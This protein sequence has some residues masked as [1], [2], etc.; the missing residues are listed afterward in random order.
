MTKQEKEFLDF[1]EHQAEHGA[2]VM[3]FIAVNEDGSFVFNQIEDKGQKGAYLIKLGA[4]E[5]AKQ[6]IILNVNNI[7]PFG[8]AQ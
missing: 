8:G 3:M 4:L 7:G 5:S 6:D 1:A 2:K